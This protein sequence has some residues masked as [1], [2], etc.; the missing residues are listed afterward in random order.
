MGHLIKR[1][2]ALGSLKQDEI[3]PRHMAL[4]RLNLHAWTSTTWLPVVQD[5]LQTDQLCVIMMVLFKLCN[6]ASD[7][8]VART[9]QRVI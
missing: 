6:W 4:S 1:S 2:Q 5:S 7:L 8:N 9:V 3:I